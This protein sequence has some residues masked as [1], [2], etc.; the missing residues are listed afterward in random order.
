MDDH[1]LKKLAHD[2][3]TPLSVIMGYLAFACDRAKDPDEIE[4]L[5]AVKGSMVSIEAVADKLG[6][7]AT[8]P[9][10]QNPL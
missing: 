8:P 10:P 5:K 3:R 6:D 7:L 9:L 4:Y 1:V 2:L